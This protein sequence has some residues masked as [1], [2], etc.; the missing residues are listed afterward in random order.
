MIY[1]K[2]YWVRIKN[3]SN[4]EICETA[5]DYVSDMN[6]HITLDGKDY[7]LNIDVDISCGCDYEILIDVYIDGVSEEFSS[8]AIEKLDD[9]IQED[10][11]DRFESWLADD[12]DPDWLDWDVDEDRYE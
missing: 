7:K 5:E 8:D 10:I 4:E 3:F 1:L 6:K 12:E 9:K 2:K 11:I